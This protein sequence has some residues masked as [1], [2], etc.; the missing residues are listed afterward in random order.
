MRLLVYN[1]YITTPNEEEIIVSICLEKNT[2]KNYWD[3]LQDEYIWN[4]LPFSILTQNIANMISTTL[5]EDYN[6]DPKKC[7][8]T[9]LVRDINKEMN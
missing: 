6:I 5:I 3:I 8:I 4:D 9:K 1:V 7:K 2:I